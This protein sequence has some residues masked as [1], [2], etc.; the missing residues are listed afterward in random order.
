[1]KF[2]ENTKLKD[3]ILKFVFKT[4]SQPIR[5]KDLLVANAYH[6]EGMHVD[7]EKLGFRMIIK[8]AYIVYAIVC[9]FILIPLL[10]ITHKLFENIDFH[11]SIISTA[12]ITSA[13]FIGFQYFHACIKDKMA[14]SIKDKMAKSRIK[15]AWNIHFPYFSYEK[16]SKKV[17]DIFNETMKK[18]IKKNDLQP[19]VMGKLAEE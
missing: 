6:N 11:A 17:E 2:L 8:N 16:Y 3:K 10:A 19:F 5:F 7:P 13:F 1:M 18:E 4:S 14:K 12:V 9:T 15:E